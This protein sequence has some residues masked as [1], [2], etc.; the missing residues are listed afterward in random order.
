MLGGAGANAHTGSTS[1]SNG[2]LQ[3]E[4]PTAFGTVLPDEIQTYVVN[5]VLGAATGQYFLTFNAVNTANL[6][7]RATAD[8]V[9]AALNAILPV[10]GSVSVVSISNTNTHLQYFIRCFRK[11]FGLTPGDYRKR[12]LD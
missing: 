10:G 11:R 6:D 3:A 8:E 5:N 2:I 12:R 4:K 7:P 1:V 9:A